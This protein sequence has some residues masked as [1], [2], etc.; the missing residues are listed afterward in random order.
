MSRVITKDPWLFIKGLDPKARLYLFC[1]PY[2]GATA[3]IFNTWRAAF[4]PSTGIQVCPVQYPGRGNRMHESLYTDCRLMV[5]AFLPYMLP[6][7][8]KPFALFGHSMGAIIAFE[9]VR[10]LRRRGGPQPLHLFVS[11]RRAPQVPCREPHTF[12]LPD[13]EFTEELR[14]LNGTPPEV[15]ENPELMQLVLRIVRGD[16]ALTQ[17]YVY[18]KEPLLTCPISIFGGLYDIDVTREDLAAWCEQTEGTCSLRMFEGDH[19]FIRSAESA[20][21]KIIRKELSSF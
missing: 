9:V 7:L 5:D 20:L 10:A 2:A 12:N 11:G 19:F 14:R 6:L 8:D 3:Q 4:P 21:L 13:D 17:T 16:F 18:T 15:L 1:F